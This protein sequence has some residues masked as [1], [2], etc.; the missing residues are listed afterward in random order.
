MRIGL[1][2]WLL[3]FF[4]I[5]PKPVISSILWM[6]SRKQDSF[7]P[8][9]PCFLP[10]LGLAVGMVAQDRVLAGGMQVVRVMELCPSH[11]AEDAL[12]SC[13]STALTQPPR[14]CFVSCVLIGILRASQYQAKS[15]GPVPP[16]FNS[17]FIRGSKCVSK[18]HVI[19]QV[20]Q[21]KIAFWIA[22]L[23]RTKHVIV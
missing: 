17:L 1:L 10:C 21:L 18:T 19:I 9:I 16:L 15:F 8:A 4:L 11:L 23:N 12:P 14:F 13:V 3:K 7:L 20:C 22:Q 6:D 5:I 2:L